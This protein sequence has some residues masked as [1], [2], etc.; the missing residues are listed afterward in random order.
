MSNFIQ[1]NLKIV[2]LQ[3]KLKKCTYVILKSIKSDIITQIKKSDPKARPMC[4]KNISASDP[5]ITIP[6]P[7]P[8]F[9]QPLPHQLGFKLG[10]GC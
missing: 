3:K 8:R 10:L 2:K 9:C 6:K 7:G 5:G 1:I 4:L